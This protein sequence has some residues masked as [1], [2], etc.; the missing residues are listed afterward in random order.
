MTGA[1]AHEVAD[2]WDAA[3]ARGPVTAA[4]V[5]ADGL[6]VGSEG[7]PGKGSYVTPTSEA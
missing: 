1:P 4:G 7:V 6:G 3:V 2:A 5:A